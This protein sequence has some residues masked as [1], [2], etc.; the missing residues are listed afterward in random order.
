L[1]S[2]AIGVYSPCGHSSAQGVLL[3]PL[4]AV[5]R[6]GGEREGGGSA[7]VQPPGDHVGSATASENADGG[8]LPLCPGERDG[9]DPADGGFYRDRVDDAVVGER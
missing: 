5:G 2:A 4:R 3:L 9:P 7:D 1:V 6:L 8:E